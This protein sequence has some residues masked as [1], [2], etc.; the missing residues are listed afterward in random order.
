MDEIGEGGPL[1]LC[2]DD[3]CTPGTFWLNPCLARDADGN[4]VDPET[5]M[6]KTMRAAQDGAAVDG[7]AVDGAMDGGDGISDE[8]ELARHILGDLEDPA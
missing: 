3:L 7:A 1:A 5:G 8:A 2:I 4:A 6:P